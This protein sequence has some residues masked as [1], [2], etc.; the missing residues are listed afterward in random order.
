MV[1][2][3]ELTAAEAVEAVAEE[4]RKEHPEIGKNTRKNESA[5]PREPKA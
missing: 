3:Y 2:L 5:F 4:L 1:E